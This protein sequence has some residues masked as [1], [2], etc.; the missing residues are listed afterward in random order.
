MSKE[1]KQRPSAVWIAGGLAV[2]A[3]VLLGVLWF[4]RNG[5]DGGQQY[6]WYKGKPSQA[7][8]APDRK[9][10]F[11][12]G[13]TDLPADARIFQQYGIASQQI[14]RL[15]YE[16][17]VR[18]TRAKEV[19]P[20]LAASVA[21]SED[22]RTAEVT[23]N[24][25][26]F[27][28]GTPVTA[29]DVVDSYRLLNEP[30]SNNPLKP[31]MAAIE[32]MDAYQHGE[33]DTF[34]VQVLEENKVQF[35]F[36]SASVDNLEALNAPIVK[37]AEGG[38]FALGT[39][40]YRIDWMQGMEEVR[41]VRNAEGK[42][43]LPY[44]QI[45]FLNATRQRIEQ[46]AEDCSIDAVQINVGALAD[47]MKEAGGYDIYAYPG[48][49]R[50]YL[51]FSAEASPVVRQAVNAMFDRTAFWAEVEPTMDAEGGY[52]PAEPF[53]SPTYHG[54]TPFGT[55]GNPKKLAKALEEERGEAVL[56]LRMDSSAFSMSRL[57]IL[58][59]QFQAYGVRL[60]PVYEGEVQ[61]GSTYD[62]TFAAGETGT[63][64]QIL[65]DG[66]AEEVVSASAERIAD[67]LHRDYRQVYGVLEQEAGEY[68]PVIPAGAQAVY[69]AVLAN[70][71]NSDIQFLL[72][73]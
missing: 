1:K 15:V 18:V 52:V 20:V 29:Q 28:D 27:S 32:G 40:G 59:R 38:S 70:A 23:L 11:V 3:V 49:A 44:E 51:R 57:Q 43:D 10:E 34:G 5:S 60:E 4:V 30:I 55:E 65:W 33:S 9:N 53:V 21:F 35:Q 72:M 54:D 31:V 39:G 67:Q 61:T 8:K 22:G 13:G 14:C 62:F 17:L 7:D 46:S 45:R 69:W 37:A 2:L 48:G 47:R 68:M 25:R 42:T 36:V 12:I 56:Y 73:G 6:L 19:T 50:A 24:A 66:A 63:P 16:P 71:R 64:E 26:N 41:L 58:E